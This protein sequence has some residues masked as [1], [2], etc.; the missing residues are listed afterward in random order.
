MTNRIHHRSLQLR[1]PPDLGH[2]I[3]LEHHHRRNCLHLF[4]PYLDRKLCQRESFDRQTLIGKVLLAKEVY[5]P[6][7][8]TIGNSNRILDSLHVVHRL[9]RRFGLR[10]LSKS[11]EAESAAPTRVTVFNDNLHD[12]FRSDY[13][14]RERIVQLP[15]LFR[16]LQIWSEASHHPY[17]KLGRYSGQWAICNHTKEHGDITRWKVSTLPLMDVASLE[18]LM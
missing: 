9:Y 8:N 5:R 2:H 7:A 18:D 17:A 3:H 15:R 4:G 12:W 1:H 10:F 14:E 11:N 16:T 6:N 13:E